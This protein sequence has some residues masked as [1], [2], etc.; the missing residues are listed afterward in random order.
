MDTIKTKD[1]LY[2]GKELL[3]VVD[4][5]RV[6]GWQGFYTI[7]TPSRLCS[8]IV[9]VKDCEDYDMSKHQA[10][11]DLVGYEKMSLKDAIRVANLIVK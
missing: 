5:P 9:N 1:V 8:S 7:L 4:E 2:D 10:V 11:M 3:K 6:M